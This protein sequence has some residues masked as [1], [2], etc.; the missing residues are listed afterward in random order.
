MKYLFLLSILAFAVVSFTF[1]NVFETAHIYQKSPLNGGGA[2]A[3]RS[4]APGEQNCTA[5]HSGSV[6]NGNNENVLTLLN[7]GNPVT[8]Y[9]PGQTYTVSLSMSS[10]PTKKGFQSTALDANNIM[11]GSFICQA[12]N[13]SK[14]RTKKK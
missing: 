9:T 1:K 14:K 8:N 13:T 3:G 6:L 11:A 12:G 2:P 5:C 10:N 4:G 7:G